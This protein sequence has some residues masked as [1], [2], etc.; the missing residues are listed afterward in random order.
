VALVLAEGFSGKFFTVF[1]NSGFIQFKPSGEPGKLKFSFRG[2]D[3]KVLIR[4]EEGKT[5]LRI[6][7]ISSTSMINYSCSGCE[8]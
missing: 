1:V 3:E 2:W 6:S 5:V 4:M 8:L 7:D